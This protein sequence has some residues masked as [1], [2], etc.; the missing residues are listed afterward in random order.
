MKRFLF[1]LSVALLIN[2]CVNPIAWIAVICVVSQQ[3]FYIP[4]AAR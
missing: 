2:L 4:A 1:V 3:C